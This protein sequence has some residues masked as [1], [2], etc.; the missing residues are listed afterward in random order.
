M[1]GPRRP[2]AKG[3]GGCDDKRW[4]TDLARRTNN[5]QTLSSAWGNGARRH[6]AYRVSSN[7]DPGRGD[8]QGRHLR[9]LLQ[10][11]LRRAH[12][13]GFHRGDRDRDRSRSPSRPA[14]HGWSSWR[15]PRA[16]TSPRPTSVMMAQ[17][18]R[19]KGQ[20]A[21]LWAPLDEAKLPNTKNLE[22][23]FVQR[24]P[25]GADQRASAR[26]RGTSRW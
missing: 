13:P 4:R 11:F 5:R 19:I 21:E 9:R 18:T 25:D 12:L 2:S 6:I 26:S 3:Q 8:P 7:S 23:H 15:P 24:Y 22:P 1:S 14:R 16:A 10:G 17:V 20:N